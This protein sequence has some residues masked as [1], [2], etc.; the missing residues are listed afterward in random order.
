MPKKYSM[1]KVMNS[2]G[3]PRSGCDGRIMAKFLITTIQANFCCLL[4]ASLG[5]GTELLL[6]K[7]LPLSYHHSHFWTTTFDVIYA[8]NCLLNLIS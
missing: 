4:Q 2:K 7:I 8:D 5:I 6:L 1:K 3:Q